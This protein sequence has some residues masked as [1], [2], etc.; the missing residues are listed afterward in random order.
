[1]ANVLDDRPRREPER[2]L[3][4]T[5]GTMEAGEARQEDESNDSSSVSSMRPECSSTRN[6]PTGA[7]DV[8][9]TA[10]P[11]EVTTVFRARESGWRRVFVACGVPV[12][13][14]SAHISSAMPE[15]Q[16]LVAIGSLV[17]CPSI[18]WRRTT[19]FKIN[20]RN[21]TT[22]QVRHFRLGSH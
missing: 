14:E 7:A 8:K 1:M 11:P 2:T 6:A 9:A 22:C 18:R 3:G 13:D 12:G 21:Q 17:T 20:R 10:E 16:Q 15:R 19:Q 4:G 5:D